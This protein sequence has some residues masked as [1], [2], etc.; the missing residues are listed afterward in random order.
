MKRII[1][2]I[3]VTILSIAAAVGAWFADM[4]REALLNNATTYKCYALT[5]RVVKADRDNDIV[6]CEDSNGNLWEF[7]GVEDWEVDDC[8][9][10]LMNNKGTENIYDDEIIRAFYAAWSLS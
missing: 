4:H 1:I 9:S 10:L 7:Y 2:I 8:A 5:T 3:T 6:T